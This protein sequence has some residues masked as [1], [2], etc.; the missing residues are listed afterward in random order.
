[1]FWIWD[2]L[3]KKHGEGLREREGLPESSGLQGHAEF[4]RLTRREEEGSR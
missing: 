4:S 3:E 2:A 1:M